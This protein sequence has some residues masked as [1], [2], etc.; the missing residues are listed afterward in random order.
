MRVYISA[1]R[2]A[3]A[4]VVGS[5][6]LAGSAAPAEPALKILLEGRYAAMKTAVAAHDSDAMSA[7]LSPDFASIEISGETRRAADLIAEMAQMKPDAHKTSKTT[8]T[9]VQQKGDTATVHQRYEMHT[10]KPGPDGVA[11][12]IDLVALSTDTWV[13]TRNAW[14]M[15]QTVTNE[16]TYSVDGQ[17]VAHKTAK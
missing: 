3:A 14:L 16:M 5:A 4:F 2:W 11:H 12:K 15:S 17:V 9:S 13:K 7:L 1:V 6:L 8:L 10:V